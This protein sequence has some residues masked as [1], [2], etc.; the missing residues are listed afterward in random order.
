M[1]IHTDRK[2][3]EVTIAISGR[4]DFN[5]HRE[6]REA[7][8]AVSDGARCV[9]DLEKATYLDSSALGMLLLLKDASK[10][11]RIIKCS[12][13]VR[14]VLEIANFHRLFDVS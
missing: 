12:D 4:F 6:F 8:K 3:N 9:V 5:A 10:D 2:D 1:T 14:K 13:E 7:V 11:V